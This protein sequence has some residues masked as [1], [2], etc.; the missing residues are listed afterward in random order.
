MDWKQSLVPQNGGGITILMMLVSIASVLGI[1]YIDAYY[2][3]HIWV[4]SPVC[5]SNKFLAIATALSAFMF[6]LNLKIK[7]SKLIN[8]I[9]ASTFGVLCIHANS[10][11]MRQ[12]LWQDIVDCSQ[13]FYRDEA[14]LYALAVVI[15][16]FFVC[17]MIDYLRI[18]TIEKLVFFYIDKYFLRK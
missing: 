12:W 15:I 1:V 16:I 14:C 7:Q 2:G 6:F 3:K 17:I 18:H 4:Y 10:D 13:S 5:D 9:A 8:T 11:T